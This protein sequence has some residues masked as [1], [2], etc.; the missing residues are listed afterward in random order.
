MEEG[1]NSKIMFRNCLKGRVG[2]QKAEE[3]GEV[4]TLVSKV[5]SC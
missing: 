5:R 4:T 2:S 3:G 1:R